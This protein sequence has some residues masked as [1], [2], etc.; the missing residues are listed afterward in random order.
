MTC[1]SVAAPG[2]RRFR[3][4]S[5]PGSRRRTSPASSRRS[6]SSSSRSEQANSAPKGTVFDSI[7]PPGSNADVGS[8]VT[9][10]VSTGPQPVAVPPAKGLTLDQATRQLAQ[11]GFTN[12]NTPIPETSNSIA[13]GAVIRT[14]PA[15]GKQVTL[16]TRINIYVSSGAPTVLLPGKI[17]ET[18]A[19]AKAELEAQGFTVSTLNHVDDANVGKVVD[20]NPAPRHPGAAEQQRRPDDRHRVVVRT[21]TTTTTSAP[22]TTTGP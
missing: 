7:P 12:L 9:I 6:A 15:A 19:T 5:P 1:S 2:R 8:T 18:K 3:S 13:S 10:L 11:A 14:D 17:G 21:T 16:D 20:Q 4:T 22:T